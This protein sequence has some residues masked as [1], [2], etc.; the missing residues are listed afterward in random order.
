MK[1]KKICNFLFVIVFLTPNISFSAEKASATETESCGNSFFWDEL[2]SRTLCDIGKGPAACLPLNSLGSALLGAGAYKMG[3]AGANAVESARAIKVFAEADKLKTIEF[4]SDRIAGRAQLK[5]FDDKSMA[6]EMKEKL[7]KLYNALNE[8]G[9]IAKE[10]FQRLSDNPYFSKSL[11]YH[12]IIR[13][14]G[15]KLPANVKSVNTSPE[16][17]VFEKLFTQYNQII[18]RLNSTKADRERNLDKWNNEPYKPEAIAKLDKQI[19]ELNGQ[20]KALR[21]DVM[22]AYGNLY[23]GTATTFAKRAGGAGAAIGMVA[24]VPLVEMIKEPAKRALCGFNSTE[25]GQA[26]ADIGAVAVIDGKDCKIE[27]PNHKLFELA[28][29]DEEKLSSLPKPV[30]AAVRHQLE[31]MRERQEK[32][33]P[34]VSGSPK[35]NESGFEISFE[36]NGHKYNHKYEKTK[37]GALNLKSSFFPNSGSGNS[38][39]LNTLPGGA[40]RFDFSINV[41][42]AGT[43]WSKLNTPLSQWNNFAA[44]DP[45]LNK[46][47][48]L[49]KAIQYYQSAGGR[50]TPPTVQDA[51]ASLTSGSMSLNYIYSVGEQLSAANKYLPEALAYC[52]SQLK[53]AAAPDT[54]PRAVE[55]TR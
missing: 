44:G 52:Q 32:E 10:Q 15:S 24:G 51:R 53:S 17:A 18:M 46:T 11:E 41:L 43:S 35:C 13:D 20:T 42:D 16:Q 38:G 27:V 25:T 28:M 9:K 39:V 1:A 55:S 5:L 33:R 3:V 26:M 6:P 37:D 14:S 8:R 29:E 48:G 49:D 21:A 30:C 7:I 50:Q 54:T 22:K 23:K 47:Q 31:A 4:G 45:L 12:R 34:I 40:D 36:V 2:K 19:S